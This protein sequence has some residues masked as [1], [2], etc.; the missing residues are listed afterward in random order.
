MDKDSKEVYIEGQVVDVTNGVIFPGEV[1]VKDGRIIHVG[2][3]GSANRRIIMPGLVD[4]HVH[5]ESS[6]LPPSEFARLAAVHGTVATVSDPHEIGNVLGVK[7][8]EFMLEDGRR[9]PFKFLFGAPSCVPATHFETAGATID[10]ERVE[11]LLHQP[12]IGYLA[13]MMN[14]PGV[15]NKDPGVI[16]KIEAAKRLGKPIDGHAPGLNGQNARNYIAA[17]ISTDH[18][19]FTLEEAREKLEFGMKIIVREGSAA[20][21]FDTLIPLLNEFPDRIMFC[22]DDKHPDALVDGHMDELVNRTLKLGYNPIDVLRAVTLNPARHYGLNVGMLRV[23]DPAD[24]I[25][26][27]SLDDFKPMATY[28]DG[29]R[30]A[31]NGKALLNHIGSRLVNHFN[32]APIYSDDI[33]IGVHGKMIRVIRAIDGQ[34]ITEE[35]TMQPTVSNSK[36]ASDVK[37]DCLKLVVVNRYKKATPAV[38]FVTGFG[39]KRGAIASTIA[40]DSHNIIAVG[41]HDTDIV[42]AVNMLVAK[43]GGLS[44]SGGSESAAMSL[45]IA[46][47]MSDADGYQ[48]AN[49]Y[50]RLDRLAKK[51][52][53]TMTAPYMTLSFM[54]LLVIP[55]LK[56]GD[57]GLFDAKEFSFV[58]LFL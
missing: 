27:P 5:I 52:G 47:L 14:F 57:R 15:L 25:L 31:Y 33:Q 20:K 35:T 49:T 56:L 22:S 39:F 37:K 13:E 23:G 16:N 58:D 12:E 42:N 24:F 34:L 46:G 36:V 55:S 1:V 19:C 44:F 26:V 17:G 45:P 28:I 6:M 29:V 50:K 30:V 10:A 53:C 54:A 3:L 21:N 8:V 9:T 40:H 48:V 7:G 2:R 4:A 11:T 32:C 38:A 18:E 41:V 43:K 51:A